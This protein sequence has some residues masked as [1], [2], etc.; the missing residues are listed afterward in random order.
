MSW[1]TR[2]DTAAPSNLDF[3]VMAPC[4]RLRP[5][6]RYYWTLKSHGDPRATDEYLAP[7]GFEELI[8]SF[9]GR[10]RRTEHA[11]DV[12]RT[13]FLDRSYVVG[14]K[15]TGV[16]CLRLSNQAMVG[17]KLRPNSLFSLLGL[18]LKELHGSPVTMDQLRVPRL[19]EI[20]DRLFE[21]RSDTQ[22]KQVLDELLT[23]DDL[24]RRSSA[25][26]GLAVDRIFHERGAVGVGEML[27][28]IDCHYRTA[29]R[30]FEE[31][32]GIS[33]KQLARVIRFKHAFAAL[34]AARTARFLSPVDF[35]YFDASH[36]A[37]EFRLFTGK[38][39][40]AF[41]REPDALSTRIF[42][43]CHDVDIHR[44]DAERRTPMFAL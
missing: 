44:L 12:E 32:V 20:E 3:R 30:T 10:F 41:F 11:G 21:A 29:A 31:R 23:P 13:Q 43:F 33:P 35:G 18:S 19:R 9:V 6:V 22:I 37:K 8:F 4:A 7:D 38:S 2:F 42:G 14:C 36:F 24:G 1:I 16:S 28:D 39:S 17:V 40:T 34:K 5:F 26:V 27:R 25:V 15:T